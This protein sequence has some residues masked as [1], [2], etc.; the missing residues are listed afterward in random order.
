MNS[1]A[2]ICAADLQGCSTQTRT[3]EQICDYLNR[4]VSFLARALPQFASLSTTR[5]L[6]AL[7]SSPHLQIWVGANQQIVRV[8]GVEN[9][10]SS[11]AS[12][13]ASALQTFTPSRSQVL[14]S[15]PT[16]TSDSH[17]RFADD[18]SPCSRAGMVQFP[19]RES[20]RSDELHPHRLVRSLSTPKRDSSP[21]SARQLVG[22]A[23]S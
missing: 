22:P 8:E 20:C 1:A 11:D 16:T 15:T 12:L 13:E 6:H 23:S 17:S 5:Q 4:A 9:S 7:R 14:A 3:S 2:T 18:R 19:L 10:N 21:C